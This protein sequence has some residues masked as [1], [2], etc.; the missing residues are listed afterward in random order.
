M[1]ALARSGQELGYGFFIVL[2]WVV[3]ASAAG[4]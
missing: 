2:G 4:K 3:A 1:K